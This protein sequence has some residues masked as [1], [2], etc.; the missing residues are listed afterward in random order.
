MNFFFKKKINY[1]KIQKCMY[2]EIIVYNYLKKKEKQN[3]KK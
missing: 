3:N 1:R 2:F